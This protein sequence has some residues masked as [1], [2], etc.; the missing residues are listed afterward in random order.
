M[1]SRDGWLIGG[2]LPDD[3]AEPLAGAAQEF[4]SRLS[5]GRARRG[6]LALFLLG[7]ARG[8]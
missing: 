2:G 6:E 5:S 3:R 4:K 1:G 7:V 8:R